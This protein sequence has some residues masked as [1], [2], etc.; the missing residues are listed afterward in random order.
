MGLVFV[1]FKQQQQQQQHQQKWRSDG[2]PNGWEVNVAAD[3]GTLPW[4]KVR[5]VRVFWQGNEILRGG[6]WFRY[7]PYSVIW[8]KLLFQTQLLLVY[9][10]FSIPRWA[11]PLCD[12]WNVPLA[13]CFLFSDLRGAQQRQSHLPIQCHKRIVP[14]ITFQPHPSDS[15]LHLSPSISF[16]HLFCSSYR[17]LLC[18][19]GCL[20]VYMCLFLSLSVFFVCLSVRLSLFVSVSLRL[21]RD[22]LI[23][24]PRENVTTRSSPV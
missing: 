15:N 22:R 12:P 1:S 4:L 14:V 7:H 17:L 3:A 19:S 20:F 6:N 8:Y 11:L 10:F 5:I 23:D 24:R 9:F 16:S 21:E 2:R 13:W 18:L